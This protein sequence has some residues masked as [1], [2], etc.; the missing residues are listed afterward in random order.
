M[1]AKT[2]GLKYLIVVINKMDDGTV[3]WSK[4]RYDE[5]Q[6]TLNPFLRQCGFNIKG[7]FRYVWF[8]F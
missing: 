8:F 5:I 4:E 6:N 2:L 1:L 3:E 7:I